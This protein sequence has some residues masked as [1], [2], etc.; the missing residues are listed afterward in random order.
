M[1]ERLAAPDEVAVFVKLKLVQ[2]FNVAMVMRVGH[3]VA[4]WCRRLHI[5]AGAGLLYGLVKLGKLWHC[6]DADCPCGC[7]PEDPGQPG[8]PEKLP[9]TGDRMDVALY[10]AVGL[11]VSL[12][13]LLLLTKRRGRE[14]DEVVTA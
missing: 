1:Y 4:Q 10:A 9:K 2:G 8:R 5:A 12:L 3:K 13:A 14:E 11:F 7:E 6:K